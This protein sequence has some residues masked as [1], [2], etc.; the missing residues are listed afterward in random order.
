VAD[1]ER[2]LRVR[3]LAVHDVQVGA[4][5]AAGEDADEQLPRLRLGRRSLLQ[6]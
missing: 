2:E 1:D 6:P 3:K 4:A 5:D